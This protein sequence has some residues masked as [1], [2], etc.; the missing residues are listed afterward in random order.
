MMPCIQPMHGR[1]LAK[2]GKKKK[3]KENMP[4]SKELFSLGDMIGVPFILLYD[5]LHFL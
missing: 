4:K 3:V 1:F 5:F 2:E